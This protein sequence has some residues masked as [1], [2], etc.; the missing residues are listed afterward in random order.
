[1]IHDV[2][3][4]HISEGDWDGITALEAG[5]YAKDGLSEGRAALR[6]KA[7]AS[8]ATC[9][10]LDVERRLAG[11]LLALPYPVSEYP[12]LNR[13]EGVV[14][15]SRNL[16]LHDLVVAEES[17]GRGL[18]KRLLRHVMGTAA[19]KGYEEISL[20]AVSGSDTFWS[21]NGYTARHEV[22]PPAGYGADAVYMS[23]T[24]PGGGRTGKKTNLAHDLL[25]GAPLEDEVG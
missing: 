25:Y 3:I 2:R 20:V 10:A 8:P 17:R 14:F 5:V 4:R 1:M 6:S 19:A 24:V 12:D 18:A 9:F 21:A 16:H 15:H 7:H 22:A 13:T 11:Y 23:R